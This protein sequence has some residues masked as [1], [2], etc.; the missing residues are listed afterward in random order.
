MIAGEESWREALH[1]L[2]NCDQISKQE[3]ST[4]QNP[5]PNLGEGFRVRAK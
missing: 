2:A 5:S 3:T 4:Y 1:A